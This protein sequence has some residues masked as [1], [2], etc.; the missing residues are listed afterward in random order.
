MKKLGFGTMRLPTLDP[1]DNTK[2]DLEQ[3]KQMVDDYLAAG[4]TYFDT[5]YM[6]HTG[7]SE[8]FVKEGLVKRYPRDSFVLADK[9]PT[10]RLEKE[11]DQERIFEEQLEKCGVDY[12]D[13][14]LVHCLDV[15]NY[16]KAKKF[17]TFGFVSKLKQEGRVRKIGFSFHDTA[18]VLEEILCDHPEVDFVQI[19][20]NYL[21]W[22]NKSVQ[23]RKCHEVC[24]KHNKPII[25]MEPVKGG[26]LAKVPARVEKLF[27]E[28]HPDWSVA[29]W[30]VRF[31]ASCENVFMVLSG[32][33]DLAQLHDNMSYMN[34]FEPL[35]E[36]EIDLLLNQAVKII[37]EDIAVACTAC[38]YCVDGCPQKIEIPKYFA[39]YNALRT[40]EDPEALKKEYEELTKTN[41]KA[42]ACIRC[43]KCM[44]ACPQ[45]IRI[46]AALKNV[47]EAFEG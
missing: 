46:I 22:E 17:D 2:V 16:A 42:S 5:A 24:V 47:A 21:D 27:A 29:S 40:S 30:A 20:V 36:T 9:I 37:H 32:M 25:I 39:L 4:F 19:Q 15:E 45:H 43:K 23:S 41:G 31:A 33:S 28:A 3:F 14:Y 34:E 11:G 6:Y 1:K 12:F 44:K 26:M 8:C 13:Y 10:M 18:E 7:Q 38:R 35:N